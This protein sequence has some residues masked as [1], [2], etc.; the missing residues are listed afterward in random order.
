[1]CMV[2]RKREKKKK[3]I[4]QESKRI[5]IHQY[6]KN[7]TITCFKSHIHTHTHNSHEQKYV[8]QM[9][10]PIFQNDNVDFNLF[11]QI[12]INLSVYKI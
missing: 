11:S 2:F 8:N 10:F 1:M 4:I 7:V 6:L 3:N 12:F 5:I 9:P